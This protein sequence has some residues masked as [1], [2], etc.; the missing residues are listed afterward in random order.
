MNL[1]L[2]KIKNTRI[3]THSSIKSDFW[4]SV[5]PITF[6]IYTPIGFKSIAITIGIYPLVSVNGIISK[7]IISKYQ[8]VS[9]NI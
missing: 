8:K 5:H 2:Y 6:A 9:L 3:K 4:V 7:I 1:N